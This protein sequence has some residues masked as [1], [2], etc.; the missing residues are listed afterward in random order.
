MA[1]GTRVL[2][3]RLVTSGAAGVVRTLGTVASAVRATGSVGG[4]GLGLITSGA[5]TA[6]T[7][8][9]GLAGRVT[10]LVFSLRGLAATAGGLAL[11]KSF[12]D[13]DKDLRSLTST[14][15]VAAGGAVG[16]QKELAF[17]RAES[18]RLGVDI[19]KIG[20]SYASFAA[21][22]T[23]NGGTIDQAQSLF[24]GLNTYARV[25]GKDAEALKRALLGVSQAYGKGRLQQEDYRGQILEN[26]PGI[27]GEVAQSLGVTTEAVNEMITAG[28]TADK[29]FNGFGEYL[30]NKFSGQAESAAAG[31]TKS[32]S[33][34]KNLVLT[35]RQEA[36]AALNAPLSRIVDDVA[37]FVSR[38]NGIGGGQRL[39]SWI[40]EQLEKAYFRAK[41]AVG[42]IISVYVLMTRGFTGLAS[43]LANIYISDPFERFN[44]GL[45]LANQ[46]MQNFGPVGRAFL[47]Y[48]GQITAG[49][50]LTRN[51]LVILRMILRNT[52][53][54]FLDFARGL[55]GNDVFGGVAG[56]A[57]TLLNVLNNLNTRFAAFGNSG[58]VV[59]AGQAVRRTFQE[60]RAEIYSLNGANGLSD[61]VMRAIDSF[62]NLVSGA[63]YVG[64][65]MLF[66]FNAV[67][68]AV[69][70]LLPAFTPITGELGKYVPKLDTIHD[71]ADAIARPFIVLGAVLN[72]LAA[73]GSITRFA[74]RTAAALERT[75][76]FVKAAAR[77]IEGAFAIIQ[78]LRA[79]QTDEQIK[80]T[81]AIE[82]KDRPELEKVTNAV[83]YLRN[84]VA[85]VIDA[86]NG[87][88]DKW[89][90]TI[91]AV[92]GK[93]EAVAGLFANFLGVKNGSQ[94]LILVLLGTIISRVSIIGFAF[95]AL[96]AIMLSPF[97]LLAGAV[98]PLITSLGTGILSALGAVLTGPVGIAVLVAGAFVAAGV[99]I[100]KNWDSITAYVMELPGKLGDAFLNTFKGI[101]DGIAGA[102]K[103]AKDAIVGIDPGKRDLEEEQRRGNDVLNG[104][105]RPKDAPKPYQELTFGE[106]VARDTQ[107][108]IDN[109]KKSK[110]FQMKL[111][112]RIVDESTTKPNFDN[113]GD[114][115]FTAKQLQ[116]AA[117]DPF[118]G[119]KVAEARK[120]GEA[121]PVPKEVTNLTVNVGGKDLLGGSVPVAASGDD[122]ARRIKNSR[123][124]QMY[125]APY[126]TR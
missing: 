23:A 47:R 118:Y 66:A 19:S 72:G 63:R 1:A 29:V 9:V 126:S 76:Q 17:L 41:K 13:A 48:Y 110:E 119:Y 24:K 97:K 54:A 11:G 81:I 84:V 5:G 125:A 33:V 26:L 87:F 34:F 53:V 121:D 65:A 75:K 52:L 6:L 99:L 120:K 80:T 98:L 86:V 35:F 101:A 25:T 15:S 105:N 39:G 95:K 96:F 56:S 38:I 31:L 123:Q 61:F 22:L 32:T 89:G 88:W 18:N 67:A 79:G 55:S 43:F 94:V 93:I 27:G 62:Q 42:D 91:T 44:G 122:L 77:D 16:A 4:R 82:F 64:R 124:G 100:Y 7:A 102:A 83:L 3:F 30:S 117:N 74:N 51:A 45:L 69:R 116:A 71:A 114:S 107:D 57:N 50:N 8:I 85:N 21:A 14:L 49:I 103:A 46:R 112:G 40:G 20:D 104:R 10:G 92:Y 115:R 73:D 68:N 113:I 59:R 36:G 37:E 60:I 28:T 12:I 78:G 90:S 58:G 106:K 2:D 111:F 109:A 108:R 70:L